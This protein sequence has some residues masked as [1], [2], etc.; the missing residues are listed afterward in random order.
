MA[1]ET[2]ELGEVYESEYTPTV[3]TTW[4]EATQKWESPRAMKPWDTFGNIGGWD[5]TTTRTLHFSKNDKMDIFRYTKDYVSFLDAQFCNNDVV[6]NDVEIDSDGL[7]LEK[8]R[9]YAKLGTPTGY[10]DARPLVPGEYTYKDA[11]V[12]IRLRTFNLSTKLGIYKAKLNVDVEDIVSRGQVEVTSTDPSNPTT[13]KF[14]KWYYYP[15]EEIMFN[16]TNFS[17]PC[18]VKVLTKTTKEFTFMLESDVEVGKYVTGTVN[19]LATG[20]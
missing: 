15:P 6:I 12:G 5:V 2:N 7:T 9:E 8:F 20:F 4:D 18:S 11:I 10:E 17:E 16:V 14:V 13:V 1:K 19:W 3:L